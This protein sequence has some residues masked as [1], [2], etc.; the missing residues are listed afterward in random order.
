[1]IPLLSFQSYS[2]GAE[3]LDHG[4]VGHAEPCAELVSVSFHHL[5]KISQPPDPEPSS[6]GQICT[7]SA[8][9]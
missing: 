6:G 5:N 8:A 1:M 4:S 7:F 2:Q 3:K 9:R